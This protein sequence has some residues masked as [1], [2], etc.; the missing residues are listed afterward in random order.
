MKN[1]FVCLKFQ[2]NI[3]VEHNFAK[4]LPK[5]KGAIFMAYSVVIFCVIFPHVV[6]LVGLHCVMWT[7]MNY[8]SVHLCRVASIR[9]QQTN[10]TTKLADRVIELDK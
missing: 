9:R 6:L 2:K 3:E 1:S 7:F 10:V 8:L 4:L 5:R